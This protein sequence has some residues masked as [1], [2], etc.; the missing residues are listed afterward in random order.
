MRRIKTDGLEGER[1]ALV[2]AANAR[3]KNLKELSLKLG[4]N[5]SYLYQFVKRHAPAHLTAEDAS[6]LGKWLMVDPSSLSANYVSSLLLAESAPAKKPIP[7]VGYIGAGDEVQFVDSYAKGDG[8]DE[9]TVE[10]YY[11]PSAVGA[12]IR[13]HSMRDRNLFD[14][15]LLIW[16]DTRPD[17]EAFVGKRAC[18][19]KLADERIMVK[20]VVHGAEPGLYTLLSSNYPPIEDV[21]LLWCA[22]IKLV[23]QRGD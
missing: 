20:Q 12:V 21:A 13:G 9:V 23:L 14:E 11:S 4:R 19:V 16:D 3:G 15:D 18:V 22:K 5:H 2:E 6:A 10:G 8:M 7:I 1:L 17:I